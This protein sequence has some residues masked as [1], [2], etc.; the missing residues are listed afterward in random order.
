M[1]KKT[2]EK[3]TNFVV[4]FDKASEIWNELMLKD[5]E[6]I[7]KSDA[8]PA[9]IDR[10]WNL[11]KP[12]FESQPAIKA[13]APYLRKASIG[14][15]AESWNIH[16]YAALGGH[17]W[18]DWLRAS[19]QIDMK[20]PTN[21][22]IEMING[23]RERMAHEPEIVPVFAEALIV[24]PTIPKL[25]AYQ[26][27]SPAPVIEEAAVSSENNFTK[28]ELKSLFWNSFRPVW[29]ENKD[30]GICEGLTLIPAIERVLDLWTETGEDTMLISFIFEWTQKKSGYKA[31]I[32]WL[33]KQIAP[34]ANE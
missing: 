31:V 15:A 11:V 16:A 2:L 27:S 8:D 22:V 30:A 23:V 25:A 10:Y 3:A 29:E 7:P 4:A 6:A 9:A 32:K 20:V 14:S 1:N 26:P 24:A 5:A 34:E 18:I 21:E 12:T 28:D 19:L 33:A 13:Q 17:H